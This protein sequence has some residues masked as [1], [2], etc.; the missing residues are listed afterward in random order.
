MNF[1]SIKFI[2]YHSTL[3]G[4]VITVQSSANITAGTMLLIDW[5][6]PKLLSFTDTTGAIGESFPRQFL[7]YKI[8]E[9]DT[10]D[11][12]VER[13]VGV[14]GARGCV[15][16]TVTVVAPCSWGRTGQ[17]FQWRPYDP[18]LFDTLPCPTI[19]EPVADAW[20]AMEMGSSCV[21]FVPAGS[22]ER[23]PSDQGIS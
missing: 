9:I 2:L 11:V 17:A 22:C 7:W 3:I 8:Q 23:I 14:G 5:R 15:M 21:Q 6:N 19:P 20:P 10:V 12:I 4:T 16:M 1:I 18:L 13:V